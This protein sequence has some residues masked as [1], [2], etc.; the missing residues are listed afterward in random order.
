MLPKCQPL[1]QK[2]T[3]EHSIKKETNTIGSVKKKD[4]LLSQ[5]IETN[6]AT[7]KSIIAN[8]ATNHSANNHAGSDR[9]KLQVQLT[10]Q[11]MKRVA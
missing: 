4:N 6:T 2:Y 5:R 3:Q 1:P 8:T 11:R 10:N 7:T 9:K